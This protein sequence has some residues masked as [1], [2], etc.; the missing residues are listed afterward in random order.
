MGTVV[1]DPQPLLKNFFNVYLFLRETETEHK[2]GR[3]RERGRRR[4][5]STL[6]ALSY[7]LIAGART[8]KPQ[9]RDLSRSWTLTD[10]A[11]QA[12]LDPRPL[13]CRLLDQEPQ[14]AQASGSVTPFWSQVLLLIQSSLLFTSLWDSVFV[15]R[16][17]CY[18]AFLWEL[19][20][21][22]MSCFSF[23]LAQGRLACNRCSV[24]VGFC[25]PPTSKVFS[26]GKSKKMDGAALNETEYMGQLGI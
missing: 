12:P 6:Q 3:A 13:I 18:N 20:G 21:G 22:L 10:W 16:E 7:Q 23:Y 9:D 2:W 17:K 1:F 11:T 5:W 26:L 15:C 19:L 4:I 14:W 25:F 24:I 8:H